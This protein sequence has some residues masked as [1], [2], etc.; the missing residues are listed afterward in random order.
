MS[1]FLKSLPMDA[2]L[3]SLLKDPDTKDGSKTNQN[4]YGINLRSDSVT[5][6]TSI[7][8]ANPKYVEDASGVRHALEI[9][10]SSIGSLIELKDHFYTLKYGALVVVSPQGKVVFDS[11]QGDALPSIMGI[12]NIFRNKDTI[13]VEYY[14]SDCPNGLMRF[15]LSKGFTARCDLP[16]PKSPYEG[17]DV[18]DVVK[19]LMDQLQNTDVVLLGGDW[20][21]HGWIARFG[22][23]HHLTFEKGMISF[24]P[25]RYGII[26]IS[27]ITFHSES[28]MK[29][30]L[31]RL[32]KDAQEQNR[33]LEIVAFSDA[34]P[35]FQEEV[36]NK[37]LPAAEDY[38]AFIDIEKPEPEDAA[39]EK[40]RLPAVEGALRKAKISE[41]RRMFSSESYSISALLD[42][43]REAMLILVPG[44]ELSHAVVETKFKEEP[45][46]YR[47]ERTRYGKKEIGYEFI[48]YTYFHE[49]SIGR[50]VGASAIVNGYGLPENTSL[51]LGYWGKEVALETSG[52]HATEVAKAFEARF[53]VATD[54]IL[55]DLV[56]RAPSLLQYGSWGRAQEIA[57]T[58]LQCRPGD[59]TG[60]LVLAIASTAIGEQ[61]EGRQAFTQ[62]DFKEPRNVDA[63]YS[64]GV[65]F[66]HPK[67]W[68][69]KPGSRFSEEDFRAAL[70]MVRDPA[71][72]TA[73]K[74]A[75]SISITDCGICPTL[76]DSARYGAQQEALPA[77]FTDLLSVAASGNQQIL[78]CPQCSTYYEYENQALTRLVPADAVSRLAVF[79]KKELLH[80]QLRTEVLLQ[81]LARIVVDVNDLLF[82]PYAARSLIKNL[83]G[84]TSA[85]KLLLA[86]AEGNAEKV[87]AG[88]KAGADINHRDRFGLAP[89]LYASMFGSANIVQLLLRNGADP[90]I[91]D[92]KGWTPLMFAS[93][94]SETF[95]EVAITLLDFRANPNTDPSP[96]K[97]AV[98][99]ENIT[100]I[101]ILKNYGADKGSKCLFLT[102][103]EHSEKRIDD[104]IVQQLTGQSMD[105]VRQIAIANQDKIFASATDKEVLIWDLAKGRLLH[106]FA[107]NH[108]IAFSHDAKRLAFMQGKSFH[109]WDLEHLKHTAHGTSDIS[110]IA[111]SPTGKFSAF[112]DSSE[113]R[114]S[115]IGGKGRYSFPAKDGITCLSFSEKDDRFAS[116]SKNGTIRLW[117]ITSADNATSGQQ[118]E[119]WKYHRGPVAGLILAECPHSGSLISADGDRIKIFG[120]YQGH[121]SH[122]LATPSETSAIAIRGTLMVSGGK[123]GAVHVWDLSLPKFV[124]S[125]AAGSAVNSIAISSDNRYILAG[126]ADGIIRLW[127]G[128]AGALA[129][130][131]VTFANGE[132]AVISAEKSY[133]E[134]SEAAKSCHCHL[135]ARRGREFQP[136]TEKEKGLIDIV[137]FVESSVD[138]LD[139][140]YYVRDWHC[141]CKICGKRWYVTMDEFD[142][143]PLNW[144]EV[145]FNRE[146]DWVF[147]PKTPT[148]LFDAAT[149]GDVDT[150]KRLLAQ[151]ADVDERSYTSSPV[152]LKATALM[153]AVYYGQERCVELLLEAG[154]DPK[155]KSDEGDTPLIVAAGQREDFKLNCRLRDEG[156]HLRVAQMLLQKGA[157]P[158]ITNTRGETALALSCSHRYSPEL[159]KLLAETAGPEAITAPEVMKNALNPPK[160]E[161]IEL[162]LDLGVDV[163]APYW[164]GRTPLMAAVSAT[165]V[166]EGSDRREEIAELLL[167]RGADVNARDSSGNTALIHAAQ[168]KSASG[169]LALLVRHGADVNAKNKEGETALGN[170]CFGG[171]QDNVEVLLS[172]GAEVDVPN[173][174]GMTPLIRAFGYGK[175]VEVIKLLLDHGA[176][177][178]AVDSSGGT[179]LIAAAKSQRE[180][181]VKL[182]LDRG[183]RIDAKS[184]YGRTALMEVA[185]I[186]GAEKIVELLIQNGADVNMVDSGGET[187]L[188]HAAWCGS[189]QIV[190]LLLEHNANTKGALEK[191]KR[192]NHR[193]VA[194]LIR[195]H[196]K[197]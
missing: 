181:L 96:L 106:A 118:L 153:F 103:Q 24:N 67:G 12:N 151:G 91:T 7:M 70:E 74:N 164:A 157:D 35:N 117:D 38:F 55:D 46:D 41:N 60:L 77:A 75:G 172:N 142:H 178:E 122:L 196:E 13:F 2:Q 112:A 89:I 179:P 145:S 42:F 78:K 14:C 121:M 177:L 159:V 43:A 133:G 146:Y 167:K 141:I 10:I 33:G 147:E 148:G 119:E 20:G 152:G 18:D 92:P 140:E 163:N 69:I 48:E 128:G 34:H 71:E 197:K 186:K 194:Q 27:A 21:D 82:R 123:D 127:D 45:N 8:I 83:P 80:L 115:E 9:D 111:Y 149:N 85:E 52:D 102:T 29:A 189:T 126:C 182:L 170:A 51:K 40:K 190:K 104:A 138:F 30:D 65:M 5:L 4:F 155:A 175:N 105:P 90:N 125:L 124:R 87:Q 76:P 64:L 166:F 1:E 187:A 37:I 6:V 15:E 184:S 17:Q 137:K 59:P 162:L 88:I 66:R 144:Q 28:E 129:A 109:L 97:A 131:F 158:A 169:V 143:V 165:W 93:L 185:M 36:K 160:K 192:Y 73:L 23:W 3:A 61:D 107:G 168:G 16:Q 136:D 139:K 180:E 113:I 99:A 81:D 132:W 135:Y 50:R 47:E 22:R 44:L 110:A 130:E 49:Y 154:A 100:A 161:I 134:S 72:E 183:A 156:I 150:I 193:A 26:G 116:G 57:R 56:S 11:R 188:M 191:A 62:L 68:G 108:P 195:N 63:L 86:I 79:H 120:I 114:V 58:I 95:A 84:A 173:A 53:G 98:K 101:K 19:T 32:V 174:N 31:T 25:Y 39:A 54:K 176:N 94:S 171:Y